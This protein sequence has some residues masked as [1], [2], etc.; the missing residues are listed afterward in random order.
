MIRDRKRRI[1]GV[2][3]MTECELLIPLGRARV[4]VHFSDGSTSAYGNVPARFATSDPVVQRAIEASP[5][6]AAGKIVR[7]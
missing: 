5:Q 6:F 2:E 3:G 4:R 7:C 1:Y